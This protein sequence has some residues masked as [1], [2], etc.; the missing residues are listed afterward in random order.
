MK[1]DEKL[2]LVFDNFYW[3]K[4]PVTIFG[5]VEAFFCSFFTTSSVQTVTLQI[6][7][8]NCENLESC[9]LVLVPPL[10]LNFLSFFSAPSDSQMI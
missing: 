7:R 2:V 5:G 6:Q 1:N 3:L 4:L 9:Q 8:L 10:C